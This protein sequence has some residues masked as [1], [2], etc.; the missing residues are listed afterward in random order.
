[1]NV[2]MPFY[3]LG[4]WFDI[5]KHLNWQNV[6]F[7]IIYVEREPKQ[8]WKRYFSFHK[9]HLP[10][11]FLKSKIIRLYFSRRKIYD[12]IKDVDVDVIFTFSSLW[13]QEVS[14]YLSRKMRA[15]YVVWLVGDHRKVR[16]IAKVNLVKRKFAEILENRSLKEA[17][18]VIPISKALARK[19]EEWG[20][21]KEKI[22]PPVHNGVDTRVFK[23]MKV[24]RAKKFTIAY[25]GRISPE[26]RVLD[27]LKITNKLRDV[28]FI[29][30]GKKE[31]NIT[32]PS[33]VEYVG[34][35]PFSEMPKFYNKADLVVLPSI[36]EGFPMCVLEAY[37]CEK[38]VL[39][40]KEALPEELKVFGSVADLD[41]FPSEIEKLRKTDLK[42]LGQQARSYVE[43]YFTWD[44][45][46]ESIV[47]Y[48]KCAVNQAY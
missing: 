35:L 29:V 47:E 10:Y 33:N 7:D 14:F 5:F 39:F 17:N 19:A 27:F 26:K 8:E 11:G 16:E 18:L 4:R 48:L 2:L 42:T 34:W 37:A 38:P 24:E 46:A 25:A 41:E 21:E 45:F 44:K 30:A 40:A 31:M 23:P 6:L 36:T 13:R 43:K 32:F 20:V 22:P 3:T 1:M 12:Q 15:P 28:H 9:I